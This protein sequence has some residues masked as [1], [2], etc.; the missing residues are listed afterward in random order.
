MQFGIV[1]PH[2]EIAVDPG[3]IKAFAQGAEALGFSHMLIYD[4]VLGA[5]PNRPG[6]WRAGTYDKDTRFHEP[7]TTFAFIAG[8]TEKI[9]MMTT[10]LILPQR[11]TVLVAKQA[12]EVS[13]LSNG[14]F[15]LGVGSGWN[16]IEY[17][18]LNENFATRGRRQAEQVDLMRKLW[19]EDSL[20]YRGKYHTVTAASINPRPRATIPV[21]FGGSAPA[22]VKRCAELGD[23]WIPLMG[24]TPEAAQVID[25]LK[26]QRKALGKS[27]DGFGIQA[28]AQFRGGDPDRWRS[29]AER[30]RDLGATHIAVA[31]HNAGLVG[32]DAHLRAAAAYL[33]AVR[34]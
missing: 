19:T 12:A 7:L 18:G 5:D 4:H 28:Q 23:G 10:V 8:V 29:H 26:A 2:H 14:R 33:A 27:W 6:G 31:T 16:R 22:L 11:Q 24:P 9:D 20:T 34:A 17:E 30:W 1:L 15:R 13:I 25:G 21:W 3:A 32:T